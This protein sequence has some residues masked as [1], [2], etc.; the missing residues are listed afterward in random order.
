MKNATLIGVLFFLNNYLL[1]QL[2]SLPVAITNAYSNLDSIVTSINSTTDLVLSPTAFNK[3]VGRTLSTYLSSSN[4]LNFNKAFAL[5]DNTDGK[6]YVG[7][8]IPFREKESVRIRALLSLGA[9]SN[10]TEKISQVYS[11]EKVTND[12]SAEVK[13]TFPLMFSM[14]YDGL[15]QKPKSEVAKFG[16]Q[17]T[18]ANLMRKKVLN[19]LKAKTTKELNELLTIYANDLTAADQKEI[20]EDKI[21]ELKDELVEQFYEEELTN[22]E[23]EKSKYSNSYKSF[24]LSLST[25]IPISESKY[26]VANSY[27]N[28]PHTVYF[29][30]LSGSIRFSYIHDWYEKIKYFVNLSY[31]GKQT[32]TILDNDVQQSTLNQTIKIDTSKTVVNSNKVYYTSFKQKFTNNIKGQFI[33]YPMPKKNKT[34][35]IDIFANAELNNLLNAADISNLKVVDFTWGLGIPL[36][37]KGK[38]DKSPINFEIL[39]NNLNQPKNINASISLSLPF[40]S[41]IY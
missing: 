26:T 40:S 21:N 34:I 14:K 24:W 23:K 6:L 16:E 8:N 35:G 18:K 22:F 5:L 7:G 33:F 2:P 19:E 10:I 30:P 20:M 32:N 12:V 15:A 41:I 25:S 37:F 27:T 28:N 11:D 39:I 29:Y 13:V 1:S 31:I 38:E 9:K 17:K 36:S 4:D 3:F